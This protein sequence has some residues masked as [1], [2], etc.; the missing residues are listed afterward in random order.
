MEPQ[1]QTSA[2]MFSKPYRTAPPTFQST[3]RIVLTSVLLTSSLAPVTDVLTFPGGCCF[4]LRPPGARTLNPKPIP[5]VADVLPVEPILLAADGATVTLGLPAL[6]AQS[7]WPH[8]L[9]DFAEVLL[10]S[11]SR[12]KCQPAAAAACSSL[13]GTGVVVVEVCDMPALAPPFPAWIPAASAAWAHILCRTALFM[14][15]FAGGDRA[16]EPLEQQAAAVSQCSTPYAAAAQRRQP[17]SPA[18]S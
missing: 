1:K 18:A 13:F 3:S 9:A 8:L 17:G 5:A 14:T 12:P 11:S 7:P 4:T 16:L 6:T 2:A 15:A 10:T